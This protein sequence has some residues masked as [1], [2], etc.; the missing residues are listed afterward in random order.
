MRWFPLILT[1]LCFFAGRSSYGQTL[2]TYQETGGRSQR[3]N[4]VVVA[5]A[6]TSAELSSGKFVNDM[7]SLIDYMFT[8]E[9]YK[10][11][12]PFFNVYGLSVAS[13]QSGADDP[14]K[15]ITRDTYF[16]A[17]FYPAPLERLLVVNT[18][19]VFTAVNTLVP[20]HDIV[21]VVVNDSTYGGSGGSLAVT[22]TNAA[23]PDIAIHEI[24][25]SFGL[26][27]DEYDYAGSSS[28]EAANATQE[29]NR[30]LI[31]WKHWIN[32]S[33]PVPT[34]ETSTYG[35]G[36]VG[37]FE[38]AAYQ[39]TGWYRP[40]LS[41]AMKS[42]G[43]PFYAVNEE[44]L[45]LQMYNR[46]GTIMATTPS[47]AS[48]VAISVPG[49]IT[50]FQASGPNPTAGVGALDVTWR[51]DGVVISGANGRTYQLDPEVA[52]NGPHTLQIEI[53]DPT[54]KV[55]NDPLNLLTE[56]RTWNITI[57][58]QGPKA[59]SG[60]VATALPNGHVKLNWVDESPD[61][62]GFVIER[63]IGAGAYVEAGRVGV[64]LT[65]FIDTETTLGKTTSYTVRGLAS[66]PYG[67]LGKASEKATVI[68][69]VAPKVLT[70]PDS[71]NILE[72]GTATFF[73][74]A[75]GTQIGY[76]WRK[77]DVDIAGA[78]SA[79]YK[80]TGVKVTHAG[81]YDCVVRNLVG[82][83]TSADAILV[84]DTVPKIT[85]QPNSQT[86]LEDQPTVFK[87]SVT[88]SGIISYQWRHQGNNLPGENGPQLTLLAARPED[89][90]SYDCVLQNAFGT[91]TSAVATL[92]VLSPPS[93]KSQPVSQTVT[94]G[95]GATFSIVATGASPLAYQWRRGGATIP[96]ATKS[97]LTI[98]SVKDSDEAEYD[99]VVT[100]GFSSVV[101]N[102][103]TLVL[104]GGSAKQTDY[105]LAGDAAGTGKWQW[106][107]RLGDL[108]TDDEASA[109]TFAN[110]QLIV[111]GFGLAP[112]SVSGSVAARWLAGFNPATGTRVWTGLP[113]P[114]R[115]VSSLTPMPGGAV[116]YGGLDPLSGLHFDSSS[117]TTVNWSRSLAFGSETALFVSPGP[118]GG[119]FLGSIT[120][121]A[122]AATSSLRLV[123]SSGA[124]L[125]TRTIQSIY[126]GFATVRESK[127]NDVLGLQSGAAI[128]CG[129]V[130]GPFHGS[131]GETMA[132]TFA[133]APGNPPTVVDVSGQ[134]NAGFV[135]IYDTS[136]NTQWVKTGELG[137]TDV[138]L[139]GDHM[140]LAGKGECILSRRAVIDGAEVFRA[141][142]GTTEIVSLD[143]CP[144]GDVALLAR[145]SSAGQTLGSYQSTKP[146][147]LAARVSRAGRV[148]WVLPVFGSF[149]EQASAKGRITAA[150]DGTL[151]IASTF[152]QEVAPLATEFVG[153]K[154]FAMTGQKEDGFFA[155]ISE[156]LRFTEMP[157]PQ[158]VDAGQPIS[159]R[160]RTNTTSG[161][162]FQWF[163]DGRA[164][165][166]ATAADFN[167]PLAALVHG[168]TYSCKAT[169][170]STVVESAKVAVNVMDLTPRTFKA[171]LGKALDLPIGVSGPGLS[172]TW[173]RPG[174][175]VFNVNGFANSTT[176]TLRINAM[177][178]TFAD[179]F[180]CRVKSL[181]GAR[182]IPIT[183]E[184]LVASVITSPGTVS[185]IVSGEVDFIV[186]AT[187]AASFKISNLPLGLKYDAKTGRIYGVPNVA[188]DRIVTVTVTNAA[189]ISSRSFTLEVDDLPPHA[190]G[191]HYGVLS[192]KKSWL[193]GLDGS[194]QLDVSATGA[195]TGHFRSVLG[196]IV[197]A[198]RVA[199]NA[200]N[201]TWTYR[202][203]KARTGLPAIV[204]EASSADST[205]QLFVGR[206]FEEPTPGD[207]SPLGGHRVIWSSNSPAI[208]ADGTYTGIT[209]TVT[210]MTG[211]PPVGAGTFKT[212]ITG[213]TGSCSW[214]GRLPD[215][216]G[217]SGTTGL[218]PTSTFD[219]WQLLYSGQGRIGGT[220]SVTSPQ[221]SGTLLLNKNTVWSD[222][223]TSVTAAKP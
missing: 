212:V 36:L 127:I 169:K 160:A 221:I 31:R 47:S 3:I 196:R 130:S 144:N 69:Q 103:A 109:V 172:F 14:N 106:A 30:T 100:N 190:K 165:S 40:T 220:L 118:A 204:V 63:R 104:D 138:E 136:G 57:S 73:V 163:R 183:S 89:A 215:G 75:S 28:R 121:I 142:L 137:Y 180:V 66:G 216:V 178:P 91:V 33:T 181:L 152:G 90:G 218:S 92:K 68:P 8:I 194:I 56:T 6:Y 17:R 38:G 128:V 149:S 195:V 135:A 151:Y 53:S 202:F 140:W 15:S 111:G 4:L 141:S 132:L 5:E 11:Y 162:K 179:T 184:V 96:G 77:N 222:A 148:R 175:R 125:W 62:S 70:D 101:S 46:V 153:L 210:G 71:L 44:A 120:P 219:V 98:A 139:D 64:D 78:T 207:A 192:G 145:A 59:P 97:N 214:S 114:G 161:V 126:R 187:D 115:G 168:G 154:P 110:G 37:L 174:V 124:S 67:N 32:S 60:L 155:A 55:R 87:V 158:M 129:E 159:L 146:C 23:A 176:R 167:V 79:S 116:L 200:T 12:K 84:V 156:G 74:D 112:G 76:Q 45:V 82:T 173:W 197:L 211:T 27:A 54:S 51:L 134:V 49:Q 189:G 205:S 188:G 193:A 10:S 35:N 108:G 177:W 117:G 147:L 88:G 150:D 86:V 198:G 217:L 65:E 209:N 1:L 223:P 99:C 133:N 61:E 85:Q 21:M 20:E 122:T 123:D 102:A 119:T 201:A 43:E 191:G 19:K 157:Q 24:G 9:P 7:N 25:H 58:N 182:D 203:R 39:T 105:R 83:A 13:P 34:E 93:I 206:V 26:L 52:G 81:S 41:S 213:K 48:P 170:G 22:S 18:S 166:G 131:I 80:I 16:D 50:S 164:V 171:P 72:G 29:T 94:R 186:S 185:S 107:Q 208:A 143:V 113:G 2:I 95:I 42:L 199:A